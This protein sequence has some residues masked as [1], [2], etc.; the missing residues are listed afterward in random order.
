MVTLALVTAPGLKESKLFSCFHALRNDSLHE[1]SSHVDH[2]ANDGSIVTRGSDPLHEQP[3]YLQGVDRKLTQIP[4]AGI[5]PTE[6]I[7]H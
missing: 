6:I 1:A 5:T 7:D 2:R 3:V 4:Q